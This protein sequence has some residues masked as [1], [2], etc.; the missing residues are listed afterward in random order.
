MPRALDPHQD[1]LDWVADIGDHTG[2]F[3][4]CTTM[5]VC[6][7]VCVSPCNTGERMTAEQVRKFWA[8]QQEAHKRKALTDAPQPTRKLDL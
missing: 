2:G 1:G 6:K 7:P 3:V 5:G 4:R 8:E